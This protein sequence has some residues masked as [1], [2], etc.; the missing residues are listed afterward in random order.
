[1]K[2]IQMVTIDE[3]GTFHINSCC[4][5]A[6]S[7]PIRAGRLADAAKQGDKEAE[8]KLARMSATPMMQ[9]VEESGDR[10]LF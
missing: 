6:N 10:P 2:K 5:E 8:K 7:D 4:D 9:E 3:D 1:M